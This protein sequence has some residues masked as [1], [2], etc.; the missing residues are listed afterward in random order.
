MW[1]FSC[2]KFKSLFKS[3]CRHSII[4]SGV[5][6]SSLRSVLAFSL[7]MQALCRSRSIYLSL[8][9]RVMEV[10]YKSKRE[11]RLT[12]NSLFVRC[13]A[14]C[15]LCEMCRDKI[16]QQ[17]AWTWRWNNQLTSW[18]EHEW[19][20]LALNDQLIVAKTL[21]P[22]LGKLVLAKIIENISYDFAQ[23]TRIVTCQRFR[24]EL[25]TR[26]FNVEQHLRES[27]FVHWNRGEV[28][29]LLWNILD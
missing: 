17:K 27:I 2:L 13:L 10:K 23:M 22:R 24:H 14:N 15:R 25:A 19:S 1:R 12:F 29:F 3:L 16:D 20:T 6:L 4:S 8:Q 18:R 11:N 9:W 28:D 5:M 7:S 21:R 26:E